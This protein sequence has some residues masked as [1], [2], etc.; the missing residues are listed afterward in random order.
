MKFN[1]QAIAVRP[2]QLYIDTNVGYTNNLIWNHRKADNFKLHSTNRRNSFPSRLFQCCFFQ[3][4]PRW[5]VQIDRDLVWTLA[6]SSAIDSISS[7][8]LQQI[9]S[10]QELIDTRRYAVASRWQVSP[11][12]GSMVA[13]PTDQNSRTRWDSGR[14]RHPA[15]SLPSSLSRTAVRMRSRRDAWRPGP[16]CMRCRRRGDSWWPT[17][18]LTSGTVSPD[19]CLCR[20]RPVVSKAHRWPWHESTEF[21]WF[22]TCRCLVIAN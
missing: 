8:C 21:N 13:P 12:D 19:Q 2:I 18:Q 1:E 14:R 9:S 5:P 3:Q 22:G 10:I 15:T 6:E 17:R 20:C 4:W 7:T 11:A 16:T